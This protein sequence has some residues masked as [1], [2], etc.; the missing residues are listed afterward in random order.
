MKAAN[1]GKE[2]YESECWGLQCHLDPIL[3]RLAAVLKLWRISL[4]YVENRLVLCL[5]PH[6]SS[7]A[8]CNTI[9]VMH[10]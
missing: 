3:Q 10:Q 8:Q 7:E 6:A 9:R 2:V 5:L 1:A 4:S